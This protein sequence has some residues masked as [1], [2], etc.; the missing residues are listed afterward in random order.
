MVDATREAGVR[1]GPEGMNNVAMSNWG[2]HLYYNNVSLTNKRGVNSAGRPWTDPLN[3]FAADYHYDRGTLPQAD[4][5]FSRT[6]LLE[7]P[8]IMTTAT[9]DQII[10]IFREKATELGL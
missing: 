4:D 5:L 6:S 10:R 8:P 7:V 2:L 3:S 1:T 9:C